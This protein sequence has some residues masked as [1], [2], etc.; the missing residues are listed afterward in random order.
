MT[1]LKTA[2]IAAAVSLGAGFA[3][4][5]AVIGPY[6]GVSTGLSVPGLGVYQSFSF[7]FEVAESGTYLFDIDAPDSAGSFL[8]SIN[9]DGS[10]DMETAAHGSS[11]TYDLSADSNP[12]G[13]DYSMTVAFLSTSSAPVTVTISDVPAVPVPAALPLLAGALGLGGFVARRRKKAA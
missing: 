10:F 3:A 7:S 1:F 9:T 8:Y 6:S 12:S 11:F 5:A 13:Y 2:A 4:N